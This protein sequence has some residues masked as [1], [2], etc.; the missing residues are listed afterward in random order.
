MGRQYLCVVQDNVL[1]DSFTLNDYL[2]KDERLNRVRVCDA[3]ER[4]AQLAVLRGR[5]LARRS[6]YALCAIRL[7]TGRNHQIR[8]QM[9]N[10]GSPLWGDNRYGDGIPGQQIALW[11]YKLIFE[12]PTTHQ[13]LTF[14][15]LPY[16]SVWT[17]FQPEL[18]QL[19]L[20]YTHPAPKEGSPAS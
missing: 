9:A 15:H 13:E 4:G 14:M 20:E 3:D 2:V 1:Q 12:H 16:G 8:V 6:G 19:W 18:E 17:V 11:G 10:M 5:V 7:D